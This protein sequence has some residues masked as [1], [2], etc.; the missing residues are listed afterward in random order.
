MK[1][2]KNVVF[3]VF[4]V[5]II[6]L[7]GIYFS[8]KNILDTTTTLTVEDA[9]KLCNEISCPQKEVTIEGELMRNSGYYLFDFN[10]NGKVVIVTVDEKNTLL[11]QIKLS[12]R[13]YTIQNGKVQAKVKGFLSYDAFAFPTMG[14]AQKIVRLKVQ[15]PSSFTFIKKLGCGRT[16]NSFPSSDCFSLSKGGRSVSE[17]YTI[18]V[19]SFLFK[20]NKYNLTGHIEYYNDDAYN[21]QVQ[22][23]NI[24]EDGGCSSYYNVY[25]NK[26]ILKKNCV[27]DNIPDLNLEQKI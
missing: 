12:E 22:P 4:I 20:N 16:P 5:I 9:Y 25:A 26:I 11:D 23:F 7:S 14:G 27:D 1:N 19:S 24:G 17:A 6:V 10:E 8:K 3:V 2:T 13:L 18:L 21:F 15:D